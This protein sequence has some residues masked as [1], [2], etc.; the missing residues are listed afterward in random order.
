VFC[1]LPTESAFL[2]NLAPNARLLSPSVTYFGLLFSPHPS[3]L[4]PV[5][6]KSSCKW[7]LKCEYSNVLICL[8]LDIG[9][10]LKVPSLE[11]ES[12]LHAEHFGDLD[13]ISYTCHGGHPRAI[14]YT[15]LLRGPVGLNVLI[16]LNLDIGNI[17]K[18][19][20]LEIESWLHAEQIV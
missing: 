15:K 16:C 17:L 8:Y 9:N 11:I 20:S 3:S 2:S 7:S 12:W 4:Y 19:P 6:Y 18:V 13:V 14:I 5:Q 1:G 10:I